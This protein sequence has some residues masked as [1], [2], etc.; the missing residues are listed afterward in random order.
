MEK[1]YPGLIIFIKIIDRAGKKYCQTRYEPEAGEDAQSRGT[2]VRKRY[3]H[4]FKQNGIKTSQ[5][6]N[7][8]LC[9]A[10]GMILK[11]FKGNGNTLGKRITNITQF[12][13]NQKTPH[14]PGFSRFP[15]IDL[16]SDPYFYRLVCI[17]ASSKTSERTMPKVLKALLITLNKEG[18][19]INEEIIYSKE[20]FKVPIALVFNPLSKTHLGKATAHKELKLKDTKDE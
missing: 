11:V 10:D 3:I 4:E 19:I 12:E 8:C 18:E 17:A 15:G 14:L 6:G 1:Q 13:K 16:T 9:H 20:E 2:V 5:K 7:E